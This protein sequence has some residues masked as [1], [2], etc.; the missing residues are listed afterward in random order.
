LFVPHRVILIGIVFVFFVQ[1]L[2]IG[3]VLNFL[4]ECGEST[5]WL[6][7]L[8]RT[9]HFEVTST[10]LLNTATAA[11]LRDIAARANHAALRLMN[12]K[13]H[14]LS[15]LNSLRRYLLLAQ[16]DFIHALIEGLSD[17]L[18]QPARYVYRHNLLAILEA[19]I[20]NS[21]QDAQ[22]TERLDI[23]LL[24][25]TSPVF[26]QTSASRASKQFESEA[27]G[28]SSTLSGWDIVSL[29]YV[30][31]W[32]ETLVLTPS[33]IAR[34]VS[35]FRSLWA[36]K[37]AEYGLNMVWALHRERHSSS[38]SKFVLSLF[39]RAIHFC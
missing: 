10:P 32:P 19:S 1:I 23:R 13:Y 33:H 2:Q 9:L 18:N 15:H 8:T 24:T 36:L 25:D 3:R 39:S 20:R 16:G 14:L 37:R 12:D 21:G 35:L 29:N 31:R 28:S 27:T 22:D 6:T 34:Y 4:R 7:E 26:N 11:R 30:V 38:A 17:E 5:T